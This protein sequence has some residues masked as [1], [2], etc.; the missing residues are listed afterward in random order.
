MLASPWSDHIVFFLQ[1]FIYSKSFVS[2]LHSLD[3]TLAGALRREQMAEISI[4]QLEAEIEQL[5]CLVFL[6]WALLAI[7]VLYL[8]SLHS[9]SI[10]LLLLRFVKERRTLGVAKWCLGFAKTKFIDWSPNLLVRFLR[11]HFCRKRIKHFLMRFKYFRAD[12]TE[13]L[14]SLGLL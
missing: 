13:I 1:I 6:L 12:L 10:N 2:Q 3:T 8:N 11:T 4:K 7:G 14:K 9:L 5:N